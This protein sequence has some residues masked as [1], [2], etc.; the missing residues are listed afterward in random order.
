VHL[1]EVYSP[2]VERVNSPQFISTILHSLTPIRAE[3]GR[4]PR[5][6]A[7]CQYKTQELNKYS[8]RRE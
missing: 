1:M 3:N 5:L 4:L 8:S 6:V 2:N 7:Y